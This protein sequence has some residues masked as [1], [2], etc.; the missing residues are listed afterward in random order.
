MIHIKPLYYPTLDDLLVEVCNQ[1][2]LKCAM[3]GVSFNDNSLTG[4]I[5]FEWKHGTLKFLSFDKYFVNQLGLGTQQ[6]EIF[7]KPLY[8]APSKIWGDR[9]ASLNIVQ[10]LFVYS[11]VIDYQILGNSKAMLIGVFSVKGTHGEQQAWQFNPFPYI[12]IRFH[13]HPE[14]PNENMHADRGRCPFQERGHPL[15]PPVPTQDALKGGAAPMNSPF[16]QFQSTT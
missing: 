8:Y 13:E 11:D 15:P 3:E 6:E 14:H 4:R 5:S 7:S 9:H 12:D 2:M 10:P 1:V 16:H